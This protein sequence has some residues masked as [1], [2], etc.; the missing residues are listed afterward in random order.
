MKPNGKIDSAILNKLWLQCDEMQF[1][2]SVK[3][4]AHR[5]HDNSAPAHTAK[6]AEDRIA[7]NCSKISSEDEWSL[8]CLTSTCALP[9]MGSYA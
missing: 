1:P 6:L 4:D 8:N 2:L 5:N 3:T 7:T 9:F